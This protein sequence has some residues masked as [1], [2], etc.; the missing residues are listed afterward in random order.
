MAERVTALAAHPLVPLALGLFVVVSLPDRTAFIGDAIVRQGEFD[1]ATY[2]RLFPQAAPLDTYLFTE[3]RR[4]TGFS[5]PRFG[6]VLGFLGVLLVW[7]AAVRLSRRLMENAH[8]RAV[9]AW[10]LT[11]SGYLVFAT[12]YAKVTALL[13]GVLA[14]GMALAVAALTS[15]RALALFAWATLVAGLLHRSGLVLL[16]IGVVLL[17]YRARMLR[18]GDLAWF[19]VALA[20]FAAVI[21]GVLPHA[22]EVVQR[23][24]L[25]RN[26]RFADNLVPV[27]DSSHLIQVVNTMIVLTPSLPLLPC[28]LLLRDRAAW[29]DLVLPMVLAAMTLAGWVFLNPPQ[30]AIRDWDVFAP[31]GLMGSVFL[32]LALGRLVQHLRAGGW[33]AMAVI[34]ATTLPS[35]QWVV[36]AHDRAAGLALVESLSEQR[37]LRESDRVALLDFLGTRYLLEEQWTRSATALREAVALAPHRRLFLTWALAETGAHD[38]EGAAAVYRAMLDRLGPDPVALL[39][40]AG[41]A[42]ALGD[43]T[44]ARLAVQRL[45]GLPPGEI[46]QCVRYVQRYPEIWP[47]GDWKLLRY[48]LE[49]ALRKD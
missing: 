11:L 37:G 33:L 5:G 47:T 4:W 38:Y 3:V 17:G 30:G 39:G 6:E 10:T 7:L 24:D 15:P 25:G 1:A 34:V 29:R 14:I 40:L 32:A 9:T 35:L 16:P 45:R 41:S 48:A 49:P 28:L 42:A 18:R 13:C 36:A 19:A 26:V 23:F 21:V 46:V 20:A 22:L 44:E 8:A 12:G 27:A 31:A 43:T 2:R